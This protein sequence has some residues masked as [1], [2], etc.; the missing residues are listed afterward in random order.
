MRRQKV[1]IVKNI[2]EECPGLLEEVLAERRVSFDTIDLH[3]GDA[4]PNPL[5][6]LALFVFGGPDSANDLTPKIQNEL[7]KIREA[8]NAGVPYLGIC[9]GMQ[10]LVKAAGG[11]VYQNPIKEIGWKDPEGEYFSIAFTPEGQSDPL[12]K[13]L[14]SPLKTFQLHGETVQLTK[15]MTLLATGKYCKNQVVRVGDSAYGIQGHPELTP[16]MFEAWLTEDDDFKKADAGSL[17]ND[18]RSIRM[19]YEKSGETILNNF[20]EQVKIEAV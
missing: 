2:S 6:Y 18:Y 12:F 15:K 7:R 4:F 3:K 16:A 9:L 11:E 13:G 1:L 19:E 10:L 5:K 14:S 17:R 8:L 20:L